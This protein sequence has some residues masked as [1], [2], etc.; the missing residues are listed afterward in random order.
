MDVLKARPT[1][2][3]AKRSLHRMNVKRHVYAFV[4]LLPFLIVFVGFYVIPIIIGFHLALF[5]S[6]FGV[7]HFVWF[8]NFVNVFTDPNFY[9]GLLTVLLFAVIQIP[10]MVI[11]ALIIAFVLNSRIV[12]GSKLFRFLVFL[13]YAVPGVVSALLWGYLYTPG[14]SPIVGALRHMG[15]SSFTFL[16]PGVVLMSIMN[17]V[18]WEWTGYN[19]IVF[20]SSLQAQPVE[21]EEAATIEGA[22]WSQIVLRIK[23]PLLLPTVFLVLIFS[24]V[25]SLQLFNEPFIISSMTSLPYYYTPN[26]YIYNEAFSFGNLNYAAALSFVLALFTFLA[27]FLLMRYALPRRNNNA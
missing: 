21:L 24:V 1:S 7:N 13:P 23:F 12:K 26:M 16:G 22:S 8:Q 27:S 11:F 9:R 2:Q 18:T 17:I 25:G 3:V 10:F 4:F 20:N 5:V 14:I 15:L 19:S 6:V